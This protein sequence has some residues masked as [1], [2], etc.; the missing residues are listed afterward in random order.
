VLFRSLYGVASA[1]FGTM[2]LTGQMMS[3]GIVMLIFAMTIGN[4]QI[5][6]EYYPQFIQ[7]MQIAFIV[8]SILCIFGVFAS[9]ARGSVRGAGQ[10]NS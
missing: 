3:M 8:F 2:R 9:L 4:V 1:A 6:P 5:T 7:S 10:P